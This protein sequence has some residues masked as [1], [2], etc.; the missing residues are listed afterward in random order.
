[1]TVSSTAGFAASWVSAKADQRA[2]VVE[3]A[4]LKQQAEAEQALVTILEEAAAPKEASPPPGQ[5]QLVD[6]RV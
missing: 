6:R 1:M 2:Q 4:A 5:G 3:I